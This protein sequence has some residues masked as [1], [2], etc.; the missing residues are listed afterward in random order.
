MSDTDNNYSPPASQ[1]SPAPPQPPFPMVAPMSNYMPRPA[2]QQTGYMQ[3]VQPG[4]TPPGQLPPGIVQQLGGLPG[5]AMGALISRLFPGMQPQQPFREPFAPWSARDAGQIGTDWFPITGAANFPGGDAG[6]AMPSPREALGVM[7]RAGGYLQRFGSPMVSN[8]MGQGNMLNGRLTMILDALS[9]GQFSK[10][11]MAAR[12]G[13]MK[14]M[15]DQMMLNY[16]MGLQ[17]HQKE[18]MAYGDVFRAWKSGSITDEDAHQQLDQLVQGNHNLAAILHTKG[19]GA[20]ERAVQEQDAQWRNAMAG[21]TSAKKARDDSSGPSVFPEEGA[22]STTQRRDT[23]ATNPDKPQVTPPA[24]GTTPAAADTEDINTE[25]ERINKEISAAHGN[26]NDE[27]MDLARRHA[28]GEVDDKEINKIPADPVT[29]A[30]GSQAVLAASRDMERRLENSFADVHKDKEAKLR[31]AQAILGGD[32]AQTLR[33]LTDYT[34]D[35]SKLSRKNGMNTKILAQAGQLDRSYKPDQFD[36]IHDLVK[37][38]ALPQILAVGAVDKASDELLKALQPFSEGERMPAR[39]FEQI[40]ANNWSGDPKFRILHNALITYAQQ[41]SAAES[42]LGRPFATTTNQ[43]IQHLQIGSAISPAMVRGLLQTDNNMAMGQ[44]E[45]QNRMFKDLSGSDRDI[46]GLNKD[47]MDS[48]KAKQAMRSSTGEMPD[49]APP[50]L[51]ALSR[52]PDPKDHPAFPRDESSPLSRD[53]ISKARSFIDR[54]KDNPAYAKQVQLLRQ[55]L[56][57]GGQEPN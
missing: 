30:K 42:R 57:R 8:F 21:F 11:Y 52:T 53:D 39:W 24:A 49:W 2:P 33:D 9:K 17:Q 41:V 19:V 37:R 13:N 18:L 1:P 3:Q 40:E 16:E 26:L 47:L 5:G 25:R 45:A 22:G 7:G 27:G 15:Q 12:I 48:M 35:P 43:M 55:W 20:L 32:R 14:L 46:P 6:P 31:D 50:K 4:Q 36:E 51:K 23:L 29:G 34:L 28:L 54:Y 38:R 10:N 56:S 44:L